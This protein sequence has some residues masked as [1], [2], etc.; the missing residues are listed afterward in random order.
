MWIVKLSLRHEAVPAAITALVAVNGIFLSANGLFM[1]AAPLVWYDSVPGVTDTGFFNQHFI[2]DI[3]IIQLFLGV[4]FIVGLLRPERRIG[5]WVAA[6]LWLSAHALFHL[7]EVA[8]G[9]CAPSVIPRD[10]PAVTLPALI[11]I[12]LTLW[13][14]R[15]SRAGR[16]AFA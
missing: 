2:R 12:A 14:I 13:A 1:L 16:A 15:R 6:T 7:W 3:G 4:A 5:L 8:V 10:F 9:I 11:G